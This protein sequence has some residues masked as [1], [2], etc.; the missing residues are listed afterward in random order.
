M[1][2]PVIVTRG[3]GKAYPALRGFRALARS[4]FDRP[5]VPALVDVSLEAGE[6]EVLGLLGPNGA[7]KSTLM[8][9]LA[10]LLLPDAGTAT[11]C[12]HDVVRDAGGVRS[13]IGYAPSD[14]FTLYPRLTGAANLTFFALLRGVE[15][16]RI[17]SRIDEL[18]DLVGL[19][20]SR[21][22]RFERYSDGMKAR[23]SLARAL[24]ADP[25]V[26][27]L[28]EPTRSLD[29]LLQIEIRTFMR[30]TLAK[31]LGKTLLLVTHS[32]EEAAAVCDRVLIL[33]EGRV[34]HIGPPGDRGGRDLAAAFARVAGQS[35]GAA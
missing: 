30:D 23:L 20:R 31:Q 6:G 28:D 21:D 33:H 2:G 19:A 24:L 27:F 15:P 29:P 7:G 26:L 1:T 10:T 9:I 4:P 32:L 16:K 17:P 18:F 13:Q 11:V 14:T 25:P 3:L 22:D 5:R 12:G 34:V 8:E 35:A